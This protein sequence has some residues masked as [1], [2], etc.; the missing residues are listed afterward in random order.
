MYDNNFSAPGANLDE[1]VMNLVPDRKNSVV[2]K[3]IEGPRGPISELGGV[4]IDTAPIH[5][6]ISLSSYRPNLTPGF[7]MYINSDNGLHRIAR[8][9]HYVAAVDSEY[10]LQVW[11]RAVNKLVE[12]NIDFSAKILSN[13]GS[14]PRNDALVFYSS[15]DVQSVEDTL[16]NILK[17]SD[18]PEGSGAKFTQGEC[19]LYHELK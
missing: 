13:T 19:I 15:D 5:G 1:Q 14:Y 8:Y 17:S 12:N 11:S 18:A 3:T 16:L 10:A 4:R 7:F 6:E 2:V 9:R